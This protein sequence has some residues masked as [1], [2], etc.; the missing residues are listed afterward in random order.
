M[1]VAPGGSS[2]A[3]SARLNDTGI[4]KWGD[5]TVNNLTVTQPS[6]PV[7][8]ADVGRDAL[9]R[10]GTLPK[11]GDGEAG[12]DFTKLDVT[13]APLTNQAASY[14]TTPWSCV[15]DNVTGLMWEVK[16][17][18]GAENL[19][20]A[21]YTYSW[22]NSTGMNNGGNA[23]AA[24]AGVC[25]DT[26]NCDTEK[27]VTAVNTAGLCGYTDWRLPS[28]EELASVL[29]LSIAASGPTIDTG[30]FPNTIANWYWSASPYAGN[31][32][33]AWSVHFSGGNDIA[34]HKSLSYY[35]RLVRG[36]Q[37]NKPGVRQH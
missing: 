2:A 9:A 18:A 11:V 17:T 3:T 4:T 29:N 14:V 23:G 35:V 20:A 26:K 28:E 33:H 13:G 24:N 27:Y 5:A 8:D 15:K 10:A 37:R 22:F 7:Q 12:F 36:G 34:N 31:A 32:A 19:R 25:V 1:P 30:Y 21:N 16:T 6:F